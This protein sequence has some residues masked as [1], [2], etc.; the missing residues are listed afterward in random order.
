MVELNG[1]GRTRRAIFAK[2][3]AGSDDAAQIFIDREFSWDAPR[4]KA[5]LGGITSDGTNTGAGDALE[6]VSELLRPTIFDAMW[7]FLF[8]TGFSTPFNPT[9]VLNANWVAEMRPAPCS[10]AALEL[11]SLPRQ[12]VVCLS[13]WSGEA[14]NQK[15]AFEQFTTLHDKAN[16]M[17]LEGQFLD[18]S[19]VG[20]EGESPASITSGVDQ[21][22]TGIGEMVESINRLCHGFAN[23]DTS[24]LITDPSI[25]FRLSDKYLDAGARGGSV[26]GIPLLT[27]DA[28]PRDSAGGQIVLVDATKVAI[29]IEGIEITVDRESSIEMVDEFDSN[30]SGDAA[31]MISLFQTNAVAIRART[32]A[33]WK[34]LD[35]SACRVLT[36]CDWG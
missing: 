22:E 24:F 31:E 7:P 19:V 28:S 3:V 4:T 2:A 35:P 15:T 1:A 8:K 20:L 17:S 27:T 5:A 30:G 34:L 33:N 11:Q 25:G 29:A 14:L 16:R 6:Y 18:P 9:A 32:Y 36:G 23:L 12:K 26:G 10:T 21:L 13:V